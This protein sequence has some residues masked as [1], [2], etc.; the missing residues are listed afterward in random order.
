MCTWIS[1]QKYNSNNRI[2]VASISIELFYCFV[3]EIRI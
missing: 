2:F 3:N 1:I